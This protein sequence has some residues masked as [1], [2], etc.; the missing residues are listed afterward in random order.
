MKRS[1]TT[2]E[3]YTRVLKCPT[4]STEPLKT[5]SQPLSLPILNMG[6]CLSIEVLLETPLRKPEGWG[7]KGVLGKLVPVLGVGKTPL[8]TP[9]V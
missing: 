4:K 2:I 1:A 5:M 3:K 6:R 9:L 7:E 8:V